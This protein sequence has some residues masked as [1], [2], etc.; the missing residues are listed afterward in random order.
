MVDMQLDNI[1]KV[2]EMRWQRRR[3]LAADWPSLLSAT[4]CIPLPA[5]GEPSFS[6][7]FHQQCQVLMGHLSQA[8]FSPVCLEIT[9]TADGPMMLT[10]CRCTAASL[11]RFCV[12]Q[13]ETLPGGR[14]LDLD[15]MGK[16]LHAWSRSD[17]GLPPRR[18]F[19]CGKEA[20]VCVVTRAHKREELIRF[21]RAQ[22]PSVQQRPL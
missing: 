5:R 4:L 17:I 2:R 15:V 22:L 6:V 21:A 8:G 18:C 9:D 3:S 16:D 20:A 11:K 12:E 1:L 19:L 7:W 14:L 13:E 10:G